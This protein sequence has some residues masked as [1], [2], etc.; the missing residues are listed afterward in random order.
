MEFYPG[1]HV[2]PTRVVNCYICVEAGGL[3]LVDASTPN[4]MDG[5]FS[6]IERIGR[7]PQELRHILVTH[8]DWDHAGSLADIQEATGAAVFA[9]EETTEWLTKGKSPPHLP[10][11]VQ[12]IASRLI[13]YRA[14]SAAAANPVKDGQSLPI[15]GELQAM[16]T[17]GHTPG[18]FSFFSAVTGVLFAGD[19]LSTRGGK[20]GLAPSFV[21]ADVSAARQSAIKLLDLAAAVLACGHGQPLKSHTLGELMA[22]LRTLTEKRTVDNK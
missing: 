10:R 9:G 1:I 17:P 11:P 22:L 13:G 8:A 18:H 6:A 14:L 7:Q 5:I 15:L 19:A 21:T 3:T 2:Y 16:A 4:Q 12:A 20:I